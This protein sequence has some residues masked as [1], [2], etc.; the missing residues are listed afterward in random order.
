M[1]TLK[2]SK[3][4]L[5]IASIAAGLWA[6]HFYH[7]FIYTVAMASAATLFALLFIGADNELNNQQ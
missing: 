6:V 2:N 1:N 7:P 5:V 3:S 4:S